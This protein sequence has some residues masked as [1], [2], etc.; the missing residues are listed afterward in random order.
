MIIKDRR[1]S[2]TIYKADFL[3]SKSAFSL[4]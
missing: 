1:W 3:A 4:S 2:H